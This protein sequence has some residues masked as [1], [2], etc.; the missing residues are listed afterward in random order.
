MQRAF[1]SSINGLSIFIFTY[2][3]YI[4]VKKM[5]QFGTPGRNSNTPAGVG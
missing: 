3:S 5:G 2:L 1:S 4:Q